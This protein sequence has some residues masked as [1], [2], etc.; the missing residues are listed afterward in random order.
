MTEQL[1]GQLCSSLGRVVLNSW[2]TVIESWQIDTV[3]YTWQRVIEQRP[4]CLQNHTQPAPFYPSEFPSFSPSKTASL[5]RIRQIFLKTFLHGELFF[6]PNF[7]AATHAPAQAAGGVS[8]GKGGRGSRSPNKAIGAAV[9]AEESG[10]QGGVLHPI[11][12][13]PPFFTG[14]D[15]VCFVGRLNVKHLA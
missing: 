5:A 8:G 2:W 1:A 7:E 4:G 12:P 15:V 3:L 9:A 10:G 13:I 14:S 6:T 11:P